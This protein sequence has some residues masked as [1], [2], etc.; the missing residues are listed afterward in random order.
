MSLSIRP[1]TRS[2]APW[3]IHLLR[4]GT[5]GGHFL[6]TVAAQAPVFIDKWL[7]PSGFPM[8]LLRQKNISIRH[9]TAKCWVA[10]AHGQSAA[11]LIALDHHGELE[12]HLASTKP[13]WRRQG[14]L[15]ALCRHAIDQIPPDA[16]IRIY[17]RCY[18]KS[19]WAIDALLKLNFLQVQAPRSPWQGST[20]CSN[21][22]FAWERHRPAMKGARIEVSDPFCGA[23]HPF[24][25]S[26]L[27]TLPR[28][29][30]AAGV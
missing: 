9:V 27:C 4:D 12:L 20:S 28:A 21:H 23:G 2:D 6:P 11:F 30:R 10:E 29:N 16:G 22:P 18:Q 26:R 8:Q 5:A 19:T 25:E 1:M 15:L 14:A 24:G 13:E 17:A 3:V 7:D